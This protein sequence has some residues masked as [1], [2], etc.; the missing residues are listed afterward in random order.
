MGVSQPSSAPATP[1]ET[2]STRWWESYLVRY[3]IGFIIGALCIGILAAELN[4]YDRIKSII[5]GNIA[6]MGWSSL[7]ITFG[8]LG[9]GYCYVASTPITVLH[10]GRASQGWI[11]AHSRHFWF[12]WIIALIATRG[13]DISDSAIYPVRSLLI[14]LICII[15]VALLPVKKGFE[16]GALS[17]VE[18]V[19]EFRGRLS[20][21]PQFLLILQSVIW[22]GLV[23]YCAAILTYYFDATEEPA[24]NINMWLLGAPVFW[25]GIVQYF[26]LARLITE[27]GEKD[28][29]V[30]YE[31]LFRARRHPYAKGVRDTYTHLREHSNSVFIVIVELSIL[32]CMLALAR[33]I[34][35]CG[36]NS[37]DLTE[38]GQIVLVG[39]AIWVIP[40]VFMWSRANRMESKFADDPAAYINDKA[41]TQ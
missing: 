11:D 4:L 2:P 28:V 38:Y 3:F 35:A 5:G 31:K 16:R 39:L 25:I 40:A 32:A 21:C 37:I 13:W 29:D 27:S 17:N 24:K 12:G 36:A 9:L 14:V 7:L 41:D 18:W 30:F 19:K 26:V 1:E 22:G 34:H 20:E 8:V 23:W 10:Y 15:S 33:S 6:E